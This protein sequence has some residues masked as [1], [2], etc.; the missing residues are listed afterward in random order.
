MEQKLQYLPTL[1]LLMWTDLC[2]FAIYFPACENI[3]LF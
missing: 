1:L 3:V 2:A